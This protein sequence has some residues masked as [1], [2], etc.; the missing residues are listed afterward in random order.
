MSHNFIQVQQA[1]KDIQQGKMIILVD[2]EDR[3][4]EGDLVIAAETV[5]PEAINFI[6]KEARGLICLAMDEAHIDRLE[7]PLMVENNRTQF[8]SAF[9]VSI[10]AAEGVSTGISA[11]D[12]AHTIQVAIDPQTGPLDIISPGHIFPLR[13]KD[14]GVLARSG[15]T[16]GSVDLARLAG[17][18]SAAVICE[19]MNDDGS[20]ARLPDLEVYAKKHGLSILKI[21]DLIAYRFAKDCLIKEV[22]SS[23]LPIDGLGEFQVRI[24]ENVVDKY[25]HIVL[26]KG[27]INPEVPCLVRVHSECLTGDVFGSNRCDCGW[28]LQSALTRIAKEG[29]VLLYMR[30]E[31]RGIGLVN[32]IKAYALQEQGMDTVEANRALGFSDD[33][34]NYGIGSQILRHL[35]IQKLKLLTNNPRKIHGINAY[36]LDIIDREPIEMLPHSDNKK[37]LETKK[38]KLGHWLDL[39]SETTEALEPCDG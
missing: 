4:N 27:D 18:Q 17:F 36:G 13:A 30:Q 19:I 25:Q 9:T 29:G 31:G 35:K 12:R 22:A 5:T 14:G 34:R 3:E 38:N 2:D 26:Q 21:E 7:L 39:V 37:Y 24:F 1:L 11:Q 8:K 16:E 10:E 20:M 15:H 32:K 23:K 33:H 28:Q 6:S